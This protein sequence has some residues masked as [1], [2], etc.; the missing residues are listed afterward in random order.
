MKNL[1]KNIFILGAFLFALNSTASEYKN[2]YYEDEG[3]LLFKIRGFYVHT[4]AKLTKL[5]EAKPNTS[6]PGAFAQ[7]GF[8]VDTAT[9]YFFTDHFATEL[10]LGFGIVNVKKS[11]LAGA[12]KAYGS[13][14]G[15]TG[16]KNEIYYVPASLIVQYHVAPYGA[17]RPYVGGGVNGTFMHTRSKAIKIANGFGPVLQVGMDFAFKDDTIFNIDVRKHFLKSKV[18]FKKGFLDPNNPAASDVKPT[19]KWDPIV[20]SAG[21]GFKF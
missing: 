21:F 2:T 9:T 3:D 10:S 1:I 15:D 19:V 18:T 20:V 4:D 17:F 14:A 11:A 6:K 12:S 16:K 7:N 8:G 5:P 13:G